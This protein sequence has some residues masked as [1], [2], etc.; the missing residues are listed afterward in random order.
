MRYRRAW[1]KGGRF[2]FT[3]VT[4]GRRPVFADPESIER[5]KA[6][7]RQ[8]KASHPFQTHALVI[9]PDH[10][11]CLWRLPSQIAISRRAGA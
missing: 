9:L 8:V 7:C 11:H 4:A 10:I 6:A 5:F 1:V 3:V 2:F